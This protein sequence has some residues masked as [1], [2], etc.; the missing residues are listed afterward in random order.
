MGLG[1]EP[2]LEWAGLGWG[3]W[4]WAWGVGPRLG[5]DWAGLGWAGKGVGRGR[6]FATGAWFDFGFCDWNLVL[7][8][9]GLEIEGLGPRALNG[10]NDKQVLFI[11][12]LRV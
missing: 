8:W 11:S 10:S 7:G 4:G 3:D 2:G 9:V 1:L 6:S 12:F 5:L